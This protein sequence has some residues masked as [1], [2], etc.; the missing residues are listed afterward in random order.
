MSLLISLL[1]TV[2][3]LA[4]ILYLISMLPIEPKFKQVAIAIFVI[5]AIIWLLQG[6]VG[7]FSL[8]T[9]RIN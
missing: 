9:H 3:V 4:L 6:F 8:G 5:I 7:P 1:I 2:L